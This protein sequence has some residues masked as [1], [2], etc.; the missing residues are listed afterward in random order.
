[1]ME[2]ARAKEILLKAFSVLNPKE[3]AN[4]EYH[5]RRKTHVLCGE[6]W[7]LYADGAGG[8]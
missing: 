1:M 5:L 4:F 7:Y 2:Q 3:R 8:G 6:E